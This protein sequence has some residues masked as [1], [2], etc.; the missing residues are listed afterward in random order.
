MLQAIEV[1]PA[2]VSTMTHIW[3]MHGPRIALNMNPA[4]ILALMRVLEAYF[5]ERT[6]QVIVVDA[7]R[8]A[9]FLVNAVWPHVPERTRQKVVFLNADA[10]LL[11]LEASCGT[12]VFSRIRTVVHENRDPRLSLEQ[13]RHAWSQ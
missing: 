6:H 2:W 10:A 9:Q 5:A 8:S 12:D 3:D 13:R 7:P 4:A 1:M 11:R